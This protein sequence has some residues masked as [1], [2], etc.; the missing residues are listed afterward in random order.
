MHLFFLNLAKYSILSD[1][2]GFG[3]ANIN[4]SNLVLTAIL[5]RILLGF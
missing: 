4:Y 3:T 2:K 5:L 1:L